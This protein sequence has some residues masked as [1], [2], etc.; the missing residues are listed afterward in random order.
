MN[1]GEAILSVR[2]IEVRFVRADGTP[3]VAFG[4]KASTIVATGSGK[5]FSDQIVPGAGG[6]AV[7][8]ALDKDGNPHVAY[9][10]SSGTIWHARWRSGG[11]KFVVWIAIVRVL[12]HRLLKNG[13][14][15]I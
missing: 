15:L 9:Y 12:H 1:P 6:L 7:S 5:S 11:R 4:A 10:D 13:W 3:V 8:L 2:D 14:N